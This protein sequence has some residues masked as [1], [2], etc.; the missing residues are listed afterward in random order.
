MA[1]RPDAAF[2]F[3]DLVGFTSYTE[4]EGDEAAADLATTFCEV[5]CDLNRGHEAKDVKM[6]GDACL[7]RAPDPLAGIDLGLHIVERIGPERGF[8]RVRVGIDAGPAAERAG[9]WFG[10]TVNM[11][12]RVV[13]LAP[14]SSVLITERT[15]LAARHSPGVEF[16]D[17][18]PSVLRGVPEPVRLYIAKR[19]S[20]A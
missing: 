10:S 14:E 7:I 16:E 8:P 9:D 3:A 4:R 19:N 18:G 5:I 20:N 13:A 1:A 17:R 2:I 6:I 11:A 12:A 15:R